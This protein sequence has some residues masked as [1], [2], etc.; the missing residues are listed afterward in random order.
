[1]IAGHRAPRGLASRST[2]TDGRVIGV[3]VN[4]PDSFSGEVSTSKPYTT[5]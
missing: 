2:I 4:S 3:E 5:D 1:M